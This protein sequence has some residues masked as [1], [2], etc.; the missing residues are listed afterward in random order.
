MWMHWKY[1]ALKVEGKEIS[2]ML[3]GSQSLVDDP[4]LSAPY[5]RTRVH[6]ILETDKKKPIPTVKFTVARNSASVQCL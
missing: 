5:I 2:Y 6:W 4:L 3:E 1:Q